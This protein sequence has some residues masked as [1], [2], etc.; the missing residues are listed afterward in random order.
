MVGSVDANIVAGLL[1]L[2]GC[3]FG[4]E[5]GR[6]DLNKTQVEN[7]N[8]VVMYYLT[9][10]FCW[11]LGANL[12]DSSRTMFSDNLRSELKKKFPEY[13]AGEIYDFGMDT[14]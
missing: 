11:S 9:F 1:N 13:P 6:L 12:H 4:T 3:F 10:S 8:T 5:G 14:E 7:L 2:I